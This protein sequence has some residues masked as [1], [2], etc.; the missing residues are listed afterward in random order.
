MLWYFYQSKTNET[1]KLKRKRKERLTLRPQARPTSPL[2]WP[3]PARALSS[4]TPRPEAAPWRMG[5]RRTTSPPRGPS[6]PPLPPSPRHAAARVPPRPFPLCTV[7]FPPSSWPITQALESSPVR[8]HALARPSSAISHWN[9][10]F[11]RSDDDFVIKKNMDSLLA[12]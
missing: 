4:S 10:S 12:L 8:D 2:A 11:K 6:R 5:A 7:V 3:S 9:L 1:E